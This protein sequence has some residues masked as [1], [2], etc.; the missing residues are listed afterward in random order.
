[1]VKKINKIKITPRDWKEAEKLCGAAIKDV[2]KQ[3]HGSACVKASDDVRKELGFK[4][5]ELECE[6]TRDPIQ[7]VTK[8]TPAYIK[9]GIGRLVSKKVCSPVMR[10]GIPSVDLLSCPNSC[11]IKK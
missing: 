9:T 2:E 8:P 5:K 4:S 6:W 3:Y 7:F 11:T 1:M 10:G